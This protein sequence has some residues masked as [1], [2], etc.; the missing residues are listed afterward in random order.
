MKAHIPKKA[1]IP[2][3]YVTED[4]VKEA[5]KREYDA[6]YEEHQRAIQH[7]IAVQLTAVFLHTMHTNYGYGKQRL[8]KL[9][10][11]ISWTCEDMQGVGFVKAFN[12][13][14]LVDWCREYAGI[15]LDKEIQ[16]DIQQ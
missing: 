10:S 16:T 13:D 4:Q 12:F 14:D 11:D 7:S 8:R 3:V 2:I 9:F 5:V 1:H 6:H 15:D